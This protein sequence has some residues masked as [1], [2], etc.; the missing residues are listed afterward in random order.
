MYPRGVNRNRSAAVVLALV[1]APLIAFALAKSTVSGSGP[2][3]EQQFAAWKR[4]HP[5][6]TCG[7]LKHD[8]RGTGSVACDK[9]FDGAGGESGAVIA[10]LLFEPRHGS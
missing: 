6:Y 7:V 4:G 2:T 8:S 10:L 5:E 9:S 1:V 3:I